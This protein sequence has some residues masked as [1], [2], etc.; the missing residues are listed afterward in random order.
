MFAGSLSMVVGVAVGGGEE[1]VDIAVAL[2]D[3]RAEASADKGR[4]ELEGLGDVVLA[5]RSGPITC[6][7]CMNQVSNHGRARLSV[8]TIYTQYPRVQQEYY[9]LYLPVRT[10]YTTLCKRVINLNE[11]DG[12]L[13]SVSA[14]AA[15]VLREQAR[16]VTT[17]ILE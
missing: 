6:R 8:R 2:G 10:I 1:T 11:R 4:D 14:R 5:V 13:T 7:K 17:Y 15:R 9:I 3:D 12:L 16:T